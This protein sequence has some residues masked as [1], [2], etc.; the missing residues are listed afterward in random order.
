MVSTISIFTS[1]YQAAILGYTATLLTAPRTRNWFPFNYRS[2]LFFTI[3]KLE[4]HLKTST[5]SAFGL[6]NEICPI[7]N[8]FH[9]NHYSLLLWKLTINSH[10]S[11]NYRS[12]LFKL[13]FTGI[14]RLTHTGTTN[15]QPSFALI[16]HQ[17]NTFRRVRRPPTR[18]HRLRKA[19]MP[20]RRWYAVGRD[21]SLIFRRIL[22]GGPPPSPPSASLTSAPSSSSS[23]SS[24]LYIIIRARLASVERASLP[25]DAS[26]HPARKFSPGTIRSSRYVT[27]TTRELLLFVLA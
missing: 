9:L 10:K 15:N 7:L 5:I 3:F 20:K 1:V 11:H 26:L 18:S 8:S 27:K 4:T 12:T 6:V 19:W 21:S 24:P 23:S 17:H 13:R 25:K 14:S 22:S 16:L 2:P